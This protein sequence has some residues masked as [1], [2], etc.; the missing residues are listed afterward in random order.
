MIH[1]FKAEGL[2]ISE[3][4]AKGETSDVEARWGRH[5]YH[6]IDHKSWPQKKVKRW[7]GYSVNGIFAE[8]GKDHCRRH[9]CRF[10]LSRSAA[11]TKV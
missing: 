10:P 2:N 4:A 1:N 9:G 11:R 6:Y 5:E 7:F 3:I 8:R